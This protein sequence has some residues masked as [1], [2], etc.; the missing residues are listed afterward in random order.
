MNTNGKVKNERLQNFW[1][2]ILLSHEIRCKSRWESSI[3]LWKKLCVMEQQN[4]IIFNDSLLWSMGI[5]F[6][7]IHN[8]RWFK[9]IQYKSDGRNLKWFIIFCKNQGGSM[10]FSLNTL[11]KTTKYLWRI[12]LCACWIKT[13]TCGTSI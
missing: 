12:W 6:Y 13:R 5:N 2:Y 11:G 1:R 10:S 7:H 9:I 8:Y 4:A 3:V